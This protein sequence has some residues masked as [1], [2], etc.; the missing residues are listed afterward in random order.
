[1]PRSNHAVYPQILTQKMSP[2]PPLL[3]QSLFR[4]WTEK[5]L[6]KTIQ[7]Y[8]GIPGTHVLVYHILEG[9][10]NKLPVSVEYYRRRIPRQCP[11]HNQPY[12]MSKKHSKYMVP[13]TWYVTEDVSGSVLVSRQTDVNPHSS[14]DINTPSGPSLRQK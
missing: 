7:V 1:M 9:S 13:H 4:W 14:S 5:Y 11:A 10:T 8:T 3:L 2:P 12:T 6:N